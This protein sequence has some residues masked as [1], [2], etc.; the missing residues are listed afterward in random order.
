[1]DRSYRF[2][3]IRFA[4][5]DA[6]DERVNIGLLVSDGAGVDVRLGKRLDKV[7]AISS[8][9]DPAAVRALVENLEELHAEFRRACSSDE[10]IQRHIRQVGPLL[11]SE[12][13]EFNAPSPSLYELRIASLMNHLVDP[14]PAPRRVQVR[15]SKLVTEVRR[16]FRNER[17]LALRDE[18]LASH[19]IVPGLE[20]AD[21]LV[22]DFVLKNG[23]MH[24]V[25]TVDASS[26]DE[27]LKRLIVDVAVAALT[28]EQA[29]ITFGQNGTTTRLVYDASSANELRGRPSLEAAENQGCELV[30]WASREDRTK[31][32]TTMASLAVPIPTTRRS[33]GETNFAE[34]GQQGRMLL[35]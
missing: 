13:G 16:F 19:R 22:A 33:K 12:V 32:I 18:G 20:L 29:R 26:E 34:A 6:R 23:A 31:F 3:I 10:Q 4:P 8:A 2:A 17:V 24:V 11:I 5:N 30:N 14:E 35:N 21:G 1:M 28:L 27:A 7:R 9:L 15:R 25:E